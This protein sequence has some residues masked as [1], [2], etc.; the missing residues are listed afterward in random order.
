[1][2]QRPR[3][4]AIGV[5]SDVSDLLNALEQLRRV[6]VRESAIYTNRSEALVAP[7]LTHGD[8]GELSALLPDNLA[9]LLAEKVKSGSAALC[10]DVDEFGTER[11]VAEVLLA[12]HASSVQLH[13]CSVQP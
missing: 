1:M 2:L 3:R 10:T 8:L 7:G 5:F 12:S 9:L 4:I 6:G 13:D 11:L